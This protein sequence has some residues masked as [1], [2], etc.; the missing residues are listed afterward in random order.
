MSI[1]ALAI[2]ITIAAVCL[3]IWQIVSGQRGLFEVR[4]PFG[5][6]ISPGHRLVYILAV[7]A[8]ISTLK[9]I[10]IL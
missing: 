5:G 9:F 10:G 4:G 6:V 8:F 2:I 7:I 3:F 1:M